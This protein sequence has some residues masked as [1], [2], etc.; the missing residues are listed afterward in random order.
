MDQMIVDA[1]ILRT[2]IIAVARSRIA[3]LKIH[4]KKP[5]I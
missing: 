3:A 2:M 4:V 5:L 1:M